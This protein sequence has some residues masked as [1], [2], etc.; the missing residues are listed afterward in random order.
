MQIISESEE[1]SIETYKIKMQEE[2]AIKRWNKISQN[3]GFIKDRT[4]T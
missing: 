2:K 4:Y 1:M 3:S